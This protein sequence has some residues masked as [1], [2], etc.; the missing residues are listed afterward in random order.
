MKPKTNRNCNTLPG[1]T[2]NKQ[3]IPQRG[4][5]LRPEYTIDLSGNYLCFELCFYFSYHQY[6]KKITIITKIAVKKPVNVD[7]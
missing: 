7:W 5:G 4:V 6:K 1:R 2:Q 3:K